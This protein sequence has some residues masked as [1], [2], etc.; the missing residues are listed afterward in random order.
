MVVISISSVAF[1]VSVRAH[2]DRPGEWL[3]A[4]FQKRR[5]MLYP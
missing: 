5:S 2:P 3:E 4:Y 1:P